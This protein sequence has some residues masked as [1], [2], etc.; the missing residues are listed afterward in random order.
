MVPSGR[1]F[2]E[3]NQHQPASRLDQ[4]S[5]RPD[6]RLV[7]PPTHHPNRPRAPE[8]GDV[9]EWRQ[10]ECGESQAAEVPLEEAD[11]DAFSQRLGA[12]VGAFEAKDA[13][14]AAEIRRVAVQNRVLLYASRTPRGR[15]AQRA[16]SR[17]PPAALI[18]H[19][20]RD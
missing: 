14:A 16:L 4:A 5:P 2:A 11:L 17:R 8:G 13:D 20:R 12:D 3:F 9:K 18:A 19:R 10:F 7:V 1:L 6:Y 15:R